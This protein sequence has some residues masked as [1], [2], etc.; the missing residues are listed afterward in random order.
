MKSWA[1]IIFAIITQ[2]VVSLN[3]VIFEVHE[4]HFHVVLF[5]FLYMLATAIDIAIGFLI[6]AYAKK[7]L[8]HGKIAAFAGKASVRVNQY[9][10]EKGRKFALTMLGI[11][12]FPL[13]NGFIASWLGMPFLESFIF[14]FVGTMIWY[15][16]TWLFIA[17]VVAFIPNPLIAL[18]VILGITF[19]ALILMRKMK[20][21]KV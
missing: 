7:K 1:F 10:G 17:G 4:Y 2:E 19:V 16:G 9:I 5:H 11:I 18:S 3:T 6:G 14:L 13:L 21:G 8:L 15:I 20:V 12:S